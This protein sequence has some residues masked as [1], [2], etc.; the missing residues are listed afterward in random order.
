M[1]W[2]AWHSPYADP[3]SPLSRR[4]RLIQQHLGTWL[5]ERPEPALNVVSVCAG[6]GH[7]LLGVLTGRPDADRVRATLI[8]YD[9]RNVAAA[10]DHLVRAGLAGITVVCADAGDFAAYADAGPAD[11]VLL[12]GVFGNISDPD[13][14]ATIR[15]LP[16]VCAP[17]ATVIWTRARRTPDLLPTIREW[18]AAENFTERAFHAPDDAAFTVGVHEFRGE[19][20]PRKTAGPIFRFVERSAPV[21]P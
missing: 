9:S 5:D 3:A 10:R 6:Q 14:R 7:D 11:L 16:H 1:D 4:L 2:Q 19:P 20:L 18:F 21:Q 13:V 17:G 15:A 8:E 12:A